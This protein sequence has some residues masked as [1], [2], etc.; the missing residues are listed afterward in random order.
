M[1][2]KPA[3]YFYIF[4]S[5]ALIA[6][7][8]TKSGSD[9]SCELIPFN[10]FSI[11]D[12]KNLGIQVSNEIN[13]TPAQYP[14]VARSANP[15]AYAYLESIRDK[16]LN[17]GEVTHKADF[18]WELKIIKD[19][20][21]LNAFCTPGG[22][23]YVYTGLIKF[24]DSEDDLAGVMGHEMAHADLRHSSKSMTTE[25]GLQTVLGVLLGN[26]TSLVT[27]IA[28]NLGTLKYS[29][30]HE[31]EA[32]AYSVNYLSKTNYRCNSAAT[33]FEKLLSTGQAGSTPAFL[34]THPSP[35]DRVKAINDKATNIGCNTSTSGGTSAA[36]LAFKNSL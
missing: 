30:C 22:Y 10:A 1:K 8:C 25:Y 23:I 9:P 18:A 12:D 19:D 5:L 35:D 29:R 27:N 21:T 6:G 16:I 4:I 2:L 24:L 34:S 7:S 15:S 26:D 20:N 36:Y 3:I 14:L 31:S 13:T 33:F 28:K 32:D 17:S 11:S